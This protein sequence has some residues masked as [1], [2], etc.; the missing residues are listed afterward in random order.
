VEKHR[1]VPIVNEKRAQALVIAGSIKIK[2]KLSF[3]FYY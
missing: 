2:G 1:K 3:P